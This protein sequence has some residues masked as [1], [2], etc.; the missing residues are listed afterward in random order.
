MRYLN[1]LNGKLESDLKQGDEIDLITADTNEDGA[2]VDDVSE[3]SSDDEYDIITETS[4]DLGSVTRYPTTDCRGDDAVTCPNNP[5]IKICSQQF[6]DRI[7]DCP[8]GEDES[9]ENCGQGEHKM[10]TKNHV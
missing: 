5:H 9:A 7:A 8:D 2:E 3:G 4:S 1:F 6:C 10:K